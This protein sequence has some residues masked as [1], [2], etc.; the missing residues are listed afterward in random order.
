MLPTLEKRISRLLFSLSHASSSVLFWLN[1]FFESS[2]HDPM[3]WVCYH[4]DFR[5]IKWLVSNGQ[6][7]DSNS[8]KSDAKAHSYPLRENS[9]LQWAWRIPTKY[10]WPNNSTFSFSGSTAT[11]S[12]M[13]GQWKGRGIPS[14]A[15]LPSADS[16]RAE[17]QVSSCFAFCLFPKRCFPARPLFCL[18]LCT[19]LCWTELLPP[20]AELLGHHLGGKRSKIQKAI[21]YMIHLCELVKVGKSA[22]TKSRS[23][24]AYVWRAERGWAKWGVTINR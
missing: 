10:I 4:P 14:I 11:L 5:M 3:R 12:S 23:V 8:G 24:V 1:H 6:W 20:I 19:Y 7:T 22:K 15:V 17:C 16:T 21:Y 2:S 13:A 18:P 9:I